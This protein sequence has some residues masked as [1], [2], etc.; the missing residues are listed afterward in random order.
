VIIE[1]TRIKEITNDYEAQISLKEI[2]KGNQEIV[3]LNIT[4]MKKILYGTAQ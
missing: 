3:N 4:S 2:I 1:T